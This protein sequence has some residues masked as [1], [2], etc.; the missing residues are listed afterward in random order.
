[1]RREKGLMIVQSPNTGNQVGII[2]IAGD[3]G[4]LPVLC[5][6]QQTAATAAVI[7]PGGGNDVLHSLLLSTFFPYF[8]AFWRENQ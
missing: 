1:M 8:S 3:V 4:D 7:S 6:N 2:G 5:M